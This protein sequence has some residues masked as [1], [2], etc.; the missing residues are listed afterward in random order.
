MSVWM[1][2]SV[3]KWQISGSMNTAKSSCARAAWSPMSELDRQLGLCE[4]ERE[5]CKERVGARKL[6]F[7][8]GRG[9]GEPE[10]WLEAWNMRCAAAVWIEEVKKR[11][12]REPVGATGN[13]PQWPN[14]F[15]LVHAGACRMREVSA[16]A[17]RL[18]SVN[19][20]RSGASWDLKYGPFALHWPFCQV[21]Y[22]KSNQHNLFRSVFLIFMY[23]F[24]QIPAMTDN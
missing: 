23:M 18:V 19:S 5:A 24:A 20:A 4:P 1:F 22:L 21:G 15:L 11:C 12:H 3:F 10:S 8:A 16:S 6:C 7:Q 13:Q 14:A 9:L 17:H 2:S